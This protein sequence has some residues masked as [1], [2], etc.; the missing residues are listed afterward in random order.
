ML[1]KSWLKDKHL[2]LIFGQST[3]KKQRESEEKAM[4]IKTKNQMILIAKMYR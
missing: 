1:S 3:H 2:W 4:M